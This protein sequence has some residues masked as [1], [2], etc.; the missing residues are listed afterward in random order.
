MLRIKNS[1]GQKVMEILDDGNVNVFSEKLKKELVEF[2]EVIEDKTDEEEV[3][4]D[5]TEEEES[6]DE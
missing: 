3:K 5:E 1:K 6:K 4:E 2:E